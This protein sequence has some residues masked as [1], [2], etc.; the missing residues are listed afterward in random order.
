MTAPS[1]PADAASRRRDLLLVTVLLMVGL[2]T[3]AWLIA[4]SPMFARDGVGFI[5]LAQCF[6]EE[7]WGDV[8]RKAHQHPLYPLN[9]SATATVWRVL[10]GRPLANQDW[11]NAAH[12][13]NAWASLLA[14]VPMYF[15]GKRLGGPWIGFGG[16][17][18]FLC[19]PM[20]ALILSD[21]LSEGTYLL[22]LTA[23]LWALLRG[24][25]TRRLH[26]FAAAG[27]CGGLTF[28][29]RPEGAMLSTIAVLMIGWLKL[30][31]SWTVTGKFA[32]AAALCVCAFTVCVTGPYWLT[33]GGLG[34]K[35]TFQEMLNVKPRTAEPATRT[36]LLLASRF[37]QG[38]DGFDWENVTP[39]F[40]A[41]EVVWEVARGFH[42][43]AFFLALLG[44]WLLLARRPELRGQMGPQLFI[45]LGVLNWILLW[46]LG[47][48]AKYVSERH[49]IFIVLMG[50][51][52]TALSLPCFA[53]WVASWFPRWSSRWP[54][55]AAL[56]FTA[57]LAN[58]LFEALRPQH[59]QRLAHRDAGLWLKGQLEPGDAIVDPYGYTA[60][61]AERR[62]MFKRPGEPKL[63]EAK[64]TWLVLEPGEKDKHRLKAASRV[65]E[66]GALIQQWP[67]QKK[68]RVSLY[69]SEGDPHVA[70]GR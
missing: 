61:F 23:G 67:D 36:T 8:L 21:T 39:L 26:W 50:C 31:G 20:P 5:E 49:T 27:L 43:F 1:A 33:I 60:F 16:T 17:L 2:A 53:A 57:L 6:Q 62:V 64:R 46:W 63:S 12:L 24:F 19:L 38:T 40:V 3:K 30:R 52:L 56:L 4:R 15:L 25:D 10:L 7:P 70:A 59:Q 37:Q 18:L 29:A 45:A 51:W 68:P 9:I 42:Y 11:L 65:K 55:L 34:K 32:A 28:L 41:H 48:R 13:A 44:I 58:G 22:C 35:T 54:A 14:I 47:W 69:R 66:R